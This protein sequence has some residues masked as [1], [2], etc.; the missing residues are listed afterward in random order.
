MSQ[1]PDF[2]QDLYFAYMVLIIYMH[3]YKYFLNA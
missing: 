2:F 1:K 3:I